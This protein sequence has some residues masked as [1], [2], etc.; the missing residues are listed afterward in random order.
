M[1][2]IK[3]PTN[4]SHCTYSLVTF[5]L[6]QLQV[7]KFNNLKYKF[8]RQCQQQRMYDLKPIELQIRT[9]Y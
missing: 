8:Q 2:K 4:V 1:N 5:G 3:Y 6:L 9:I 7:N